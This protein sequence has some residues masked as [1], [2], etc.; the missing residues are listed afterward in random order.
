MSVEQHLRPRVGKELQVATRPFAVELLV[1]SWWDVCF[2][3]ALLLAVLSGVILCS[4]WPLRTGLSIIGGL[5]FVRTFILY[6]DYM[7]GSLLRESRVAQI[8]FYLYGL[9]VLTPPRYWRYSHNFH[10]AHIDKPA[11]GK[12]KSLPVIISDVGA[13]P[14]MTTDMWR[15]ATFWQRLRYRISRHPVTLL[16]AY[17]TIFL[18]G[19][20]IIPLC[21]DPQKYWE[22][23]ISLLLHG[24]VISLFWIFAG[25]A[26]AL[27]AFVIPVA[28]ASAIGACLFFI[29]HNFEGMRVTT[30]ED[31]DFYR[32]TLESSSYLHLGPILR[33]FT[34]NIG[35]HHVHH[36]NAQIPFYRLP[37]TMEAI[38]ELQESP[39]V[40]RLS[41]WNI[42]ACFR[43]NLWDIQSQRL[44]PYQAVDVSD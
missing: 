41:L 20:C 23:G 7:H 29:Q 11:G 2:T 24:G 44:V 31:W 37:E 21:K 19:L 38:E 27:F 18:L 1:R 33:W 10:H 39:T 30:S 36:L 32:S 6:H 26:A 35:Y 22:G 3:F 8:L 14:L 25:W 42:L 17:L 34:G 13:F 15:E 40:T 9:I 12:G 16:C 4:W 28:I 43:L 5:I